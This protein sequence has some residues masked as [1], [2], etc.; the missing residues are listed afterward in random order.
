MPI[1]KV[2]SE[3][4]EIGMYVSSLDRPWSETPFEFQGFEIRNTHELVELQ[5]L[6]DHVF[7]I[8]P[9]EEIELYGAD[10]VKE[11]RP[12][13][14]FIGHVDYELESTAAEEIEAVHESHEEIV[15][16]VAD[17]EQM[18]ATDGALNTQRVGRAIDVMVSSVT[19]NPD[20]FIWL[21]QIKHF[22][23][24]IYRD[25]LN[26]A[27][28]AAAIGRELGMR[29]EHLQML[30]TGA[31]LMDVGKT[32]LT[33]ELLN[34][35][36]RLDRHEWDAMK[37]HVGYSVEILEHSSN[38]PL[39]VIEMVRTHHERMDGSG[40]PNALRK[41]QIPLFGQIAGIVDFYVS[42]TSPRPYAPVVAPTVATEMLYEQKGRHFD[43]MLVQAFIKVLNTFPTG[44]LV[45]LSSGEVGIVL[46]QNPRSRLRPTVV[47][48]LD[49][50]KLPLDT[51]Q[52]IDLAART[53]NRENDPLVVAKSLPDGA[54]GLNIDQIH[55]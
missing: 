28:W 43:E 41:G 36:T 38:I 3:Q 22:D 54:F 25:S 20:A 33:R 37:A 14:D 45:E 4:L 39:E 42:V 15:D 18:A 27:V 6:T 5:R 12:Y 19:S 44:S 30:A 47:L 16:L 52:V 24:Y 26:S 13:T 31:M 50:N 23:S 48:L 49:P 51:E 17:V 32:K 8:V 46:S 55:L 21:S 53:E 29:P 35:S 10:S 9:D 7:I 11:V 2:P 34:K 40:Y 1:V